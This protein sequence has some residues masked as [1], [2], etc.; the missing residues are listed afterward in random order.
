MQADFARDVLNL[1]LDGGACM[2]PLAIQALAIYYISFSLFFELRGHPALRTSEDEWGHWIDRPEDARGEVARI[3]RY[4]QENVSSLDTIR[5]RFAEVAKAYLP[6]IDR[7]IRFVFMIIGTAPLTGLLGTVTGMLATFHGIAG[8]GGGSD[9]VDLVAGGISEALITTET[10]LVI[11]IPGYVVLA[12]IRRLR[13]QLELF[14]RRAETMTLRR[15]TRILPELAEP[16][17]PPPRHTPPPAGD[18]PSSPAA[19]LPLAPQPS[20]A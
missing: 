6:P 2:I 11:A 13:E 16:T 14:L 8:G 5:A 1:W 12:R 19:D 20:P 10:G 15:F 7:R 3:F 18:E 4:T 9:T 17:L